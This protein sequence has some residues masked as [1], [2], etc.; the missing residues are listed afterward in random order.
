VVA[1]PGA[2]LSGMTD[3]DEVERTQDDVAA[4][5]RARDPRVRLVLEP[6]GSG[7]SSAFLLGRGLPGWLGL[8]LLGAAL[9]TLGLVV[10]GPEPQRATRWAWFWLHW[11]P[12]GALAF[13][14]LSGPTPGLPA[15][16]SGRRLTGG[17]GFL[18]ALVLGAALPG[19]T[20]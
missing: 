2:S 15:P 10:A 4:Q 16:R 14:L 6:W 20:G 18:L 7:V 11:T 5:V 19:W 17:R 9:T 1:S 3:R 12:V 8:A 13:L